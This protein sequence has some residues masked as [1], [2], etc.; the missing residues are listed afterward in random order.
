MARFANPYSQ[1]EKAANAI[2][3]ERERERR[4]M[5]QACYKHADDL[6]LKLVQRL[7][8][9][10]I[11]ETSSE[12][13]LRDTIAKQLNKLVDME[14]FDIQFKIA[15]VRGM[16]NDPNFVSLYLTQYIIEDLIDHP[17]V[18]DVFGEDLD[19]YRAVDSVMG[20]I[21]PKS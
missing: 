7:L 4:F 8:D 15:P 20:K 12:S 19:I 17:K 11:I 10:H 2:D 9:Q 18:Q 13:D 21:R 16:V 14:E 6:A 5:L 1:S 3:R